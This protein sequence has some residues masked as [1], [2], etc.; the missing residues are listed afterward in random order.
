MYFCFRFDSNRL[1]ED[2]ISE[3]GDYLCLLPMG[4]PPLCSTNVSFPGCRGTKKK[5]VHVENRSDAS[6]FYVWVFL[7]WFFLYMLAE[8]WD[9]VSTVFT[10]FLLLDLLCMF[11]LSVKGNRIF[12]IYDTEKYS[13]RFVYHERHREQIINII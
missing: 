10:C 6:M 7:G 11:F 2:G 3:R 5:P 8:L 12:E 4:F 1:T 9:F 13:I